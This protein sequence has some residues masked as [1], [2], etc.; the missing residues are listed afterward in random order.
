M[1]T[2]LSKKRMHMHT[3]CISGNLSYEMIF[4]MYDLCL[5]DEG[6]SY[7]AVS[8]SSL[9]ED[10]LLFLVNLLFVNFIVKSHFNDCKQT[11]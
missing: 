11:S 9:S 1:V 8:K 6:H 3:V 4:S 2:M 5:C 10:T 7:V